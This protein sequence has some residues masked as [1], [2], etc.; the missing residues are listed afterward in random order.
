MIENQEEFRLIQKNGRPN[1]GIL[2]QIVPVLNMDDYRPHGETSVPAIQR[3]WINQFQVKRWQYIGVVQD[4]FIFGIAIVR[5]G[6]LSNFFCYL[7]DRKEKTI[8]EYSQSQFLSWNTE[9]KGSLKSGE[10]QFIDKKIEAHFKNDNGSTEL[11]LSILD[12]LKAKI[13]VKNTI[14]PFGTITRVGLKG[15]NYTQK[16]AG[17]DAEGTIELGDKI[18]TIKPDVPAG[19]LDYTLGILSKTTFWNW[20]S[21]SGVDKKG[22]R[23]GFNFAQGINET[24]YTE[25]VFWV[26]GQVVK[27]D[28]V[29]FIY[30]D[31]YLLNEWKIKSND[32]KVDLSFHP[33]GERKANLNYGF[34]ASRFHQPFGTFTGQFTDGKK[35]YELDNVSGFVEEHESR[36]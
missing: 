33:E 15:F 13:K 7:F 28:M 17:L 26:D 6:Y 36:W 1:F 16:A 19:V 29:Q 18:Y 8:K 31:V 34:I 2:N 30:D 5:L 20:A 35:V 11:D 21:G 27:V 24:G 9:F 32:G 22:K 12:G 4:D 14:E 3:N 23:I 10:A 25:N